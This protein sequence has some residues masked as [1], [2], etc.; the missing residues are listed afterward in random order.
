MVTGEKIDQA[1]PSTPSADSNEDGSDGGLVCGNTAPMRMEL[2]C[3][4][5]L[6]Y[7]F[8]V[9]EGLRRCG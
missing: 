6:A 9:V 5:T 7:S 2:L 3:G 4:L 1:K 8:I